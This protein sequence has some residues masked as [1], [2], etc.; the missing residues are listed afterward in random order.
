MVIILFLIVLGVLILSHE[1]GHFIVAKK[2]GIRVDEFAFG[3]PPRIFSVKKGETTYSLNLIPFGG[4]VKIHD[5]EKETA[6]VLLAGVFFNLLLAWLLISIGFFIGLP[7]SIGSAPA[8]AEIKDVKIVIIDVVQNSPA[9]DAGLKTGDEITG[10]S[11]VEDVQNFIGKNKGMKTEI[12][13]KRGGEIFSAELTPRI[14]PPPG[15]GAIGIAMDEVGILKIP[16]YRAPW[17]GL[18]MTYELTISIALSIYYFFVNLIKGLTGLEGVMGPVGIV[19]ATNT[20]AHLGFSYLLSFVALLSINL[21]VIN[22][23]PFP[24]LDGGRILFLLIEKIKG[25]PINTRVSNAIHN[26]GFALLLIL[27]LAITYRDILRLI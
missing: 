22:I 12:K 13:Y 7:T 11:K 19:G 4:F 27:M 14:S 25:S 6:A 24:A 23:I 5:G 9:S 20:V 21:A 15:E 10:F 17:E 3:F 18:K 1:F 16:W 26:A 8:G 2:S